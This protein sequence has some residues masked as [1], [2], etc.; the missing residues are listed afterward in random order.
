MAIAVHLVNKPNPATLD[1]AKSTY[2]QLDARGARHPDGRLSHVSWIV[3]D[4]FHVLDVWES[5][6]SLDAFFDTLGPILA[7]T[8]M[9]LA[10]PPEI[11][12][13][14]QIIVPVASGAT[15]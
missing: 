7:E 10:G 13:L 1:Q 12:D 9:E 3:G 2:D 4:E 6:D 14:V 5:R 15:S 11:G 8:G